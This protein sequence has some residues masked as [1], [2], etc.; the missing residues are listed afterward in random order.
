[1]ARS[2]VNESLSLP[3]IT[4]ETPVKHKNH[5]RHVLYFFIRVSTVFL[6][7]SYFNFFNVLFISF[8]NN[9]F[10]LAFYS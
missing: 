1:M 3:N 6:F 2:V 4:K 10:A 7:A 8:K 5:R 9:Y